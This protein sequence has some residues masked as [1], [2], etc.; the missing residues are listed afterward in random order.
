MLKEQPFTIFSNHKPLILF[1]NQ[2]NNEH[3]LWKVRQ[4]DFIGQF[5]IDSE[6]T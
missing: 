4:L 3:T 2:T 5:V 1:F 6:Y